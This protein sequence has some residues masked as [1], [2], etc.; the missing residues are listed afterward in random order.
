MTI[1]MTETIQWTD[2]M[3]A[4]LRRHA[5]AGKSALQ[6]AGIMGRGLSRSAIIGKCHRAQPPIQLGARTGAGSSDNA[7]LEGRLNA[8]LAPA[9]RARKARPDGARLPVVNSI[10]M[11]RPAPAGIGAARAEV[12]LGEIR[13]SRAFDPASAPAGARIVSLLDL[14]HGE[15]KW[16]LFEDGPMLFCGCA[17]TSFDQKGQAA[18]YCVA[19]AALSLPRAS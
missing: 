3:V 10:T 4:E 11:L 19:H 6:I 13:R 5:E 14:K 9:E 15:C 1:R 18:P 2:D 17:V 8:G 12:N 16:P 7:T